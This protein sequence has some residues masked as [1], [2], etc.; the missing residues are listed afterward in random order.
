[1]KTFADLD[2]HADK[3]GKKLYGIASGS[4]ANESIRQMIAADEFGLGDWKLVESS[5]QA[6]LVQVGRAVKREQF[7]AVSY[8]HLDVYKRQMPGRPPNSAVRVQMMK[9]PYSPISG[10]TWATRAKAMHSGTRAKDEVRP[11][12][13][14]AR[15]LA[16]FMSR[17]GSLEG[18][19]W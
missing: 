3:F 4:P 7:V 15:K 1:M 14:S 2:K 11:A 10:L 16:G 9:A 6:M 12:S 8:T 13:R 5:E 19:A 17:C 18:R